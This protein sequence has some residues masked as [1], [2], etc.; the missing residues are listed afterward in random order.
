MKR[1]WLSVFS[2]LFI[3]LS[4]LLVPAAPASACDTCC[5]EPPYNVPIVVD[6]NVADWGNTPIFGGLYQPGIGTRLADVTLVYN[7]GDHVLDVMV[8]SEGQAIQ[9]SWGEA[10]VKLDFSSSA[11]VPTAKAWVRNA[12]GVAVG[13]E[14]SYSI[15][16]GTTHFLR[17]HT[18]VW[19]GGCW[20]TAVSSW[21]CVWIDCPP[22]P[23]TLAG[24][25]VTAGKGGILIAWE[26]ASE[27]NNLGFNLY[28]GTSNDVESAVKINS[29]LI[30][31]AHPGSVAGGSYSYLDSTARAGVVY[32]YWLEDV[33]AV[34]G[35]MSMGLHDLGT[36][37]WNKPVANYVSPASGGQ[38]Y[39]TS[40][41]FNAVYTDRDGDLGIVYL[42]IADSP[43]P[44]VGV[45]VRYDCRT[46]QFALN[47]ATRATLKSGVAQ[48][49][50]DGKLKISVVL[51]FK[52]SF[53]GPH[54]LYI[55]AQD[56]PGNKT[57]WRLAGTWTVQ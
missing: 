13:W 38:V 2:L 15:T 50:A 42:L 34:P 6:G 39:S 46:R 25:S 10:W 41:K 23:V 1:N 21:L 37:Q 47:N 29:A 35:L 43:D 9:E 16:G 56:A 4:F 48:V 17:F 30:P 40:Q 33:E 45:Q 22:T 53:V 24:F 49:L 44:T 18:N 26:T 3:L 55:R 5:P 12:D 51:T 32:H 54:N 31:T 11:L 7:C 20:Q 57:V 19:S 36:G 27:I 28:R 52:A 14:A 8:L